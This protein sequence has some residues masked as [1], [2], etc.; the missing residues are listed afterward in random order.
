MLLL[1]RLPKTVH[2]RP[3]HAHDLPRLRLHEF[4]APFADVGDLVDP[5]REGCGVI[6][7][8]EF[9][10]V[11]QAGGRVGDEVGGGAGEIWGRLVKL[12]KVWVR[13]GTFEEM[14]DAG[15]GR[16]DGKD[17]AGVVYVHF[18]VRV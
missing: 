15:V 10:L 9:P 5:D 12:Q 2:P 18:D 16:P 1:H 13:A 7:R 6:A 3:Q 14:E 4:L 8:R 17:A 11:G